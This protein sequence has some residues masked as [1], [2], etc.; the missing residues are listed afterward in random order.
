MTTPALACWYC[1]VRAMHSQSDDAPAAAVTTY[2]GTA[3]CR[4]CV[5]QALREAEMT[6]MERRM[7][8]TRRRTRATL[9][10]N[11]AEH[12]QELAGMATDDPSRERQE[13]LLNSFRQILAK[14]DE[15]D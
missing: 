4:A 10:N 12:E 3:V 13:T 8:I 2:L 14:L 15:D 11:I 7:A 9:V 6:D 5:E 1:T